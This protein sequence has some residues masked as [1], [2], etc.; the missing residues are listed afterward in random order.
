VTS[1]VLPLLEFADTSP[2]GRVAMSADAPP[3]DVIRRAQA[4]DAGAFRALYEAHVGRVHALCLRLSGDRREAEELTQDVFVRVWE[5]L[6]T[7]RGDSAFSTWLHRLAVNAVLTARRSA[8]RRHRRV[9]TDAT[10]PDAPGASRDV[11]TI[12]DLERAIAGLPE[13]C[14]SVFVLYDVEGWRHDE[15][16]AE[17]RIAVG[18][19]KAHLFRARRLLREALDR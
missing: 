10:A 12:M 2:S 9:R 6:E 11:G 13:G 3:P 16:A 1:A 15:I 19:C 17:L 14:R 4:G 7:F 18:T 8:A 5:R